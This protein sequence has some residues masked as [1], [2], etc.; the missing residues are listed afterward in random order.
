[1][2]ELLG[3]PEDRFSYDTVHFMG[4]YFVFQQL[5]AVV[6]N[7]LL[8]AMHTRLPSSY[9]KR[10]RHRLKAA[11]DMYATS[12]KRPLTDRGSLTVMT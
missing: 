10:Y 11:V 12:A 8:G 5:M 3:N 7:I 4:N 6:L 2:L 9:R 1:M